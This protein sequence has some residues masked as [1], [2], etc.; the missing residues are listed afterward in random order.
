DLEAFSTTITI[1]PDLPSDVVTRSFDE[2]T[3]SARPA[4]GL[5]IGLGGGVLAVLGALLSYRF[6]PPVAEGSASSF[7]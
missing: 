7:G 5:F 1:S 3:L 6:T 4:I 2:G